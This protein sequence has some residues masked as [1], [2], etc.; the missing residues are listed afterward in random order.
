MY[1]QASVSKIVLPEQFDLGSV[2]SYNIPPPLDNPH[3]VRHKNITQ[4][5][6]NINNPKHIT[7][8]CFMPRRKI[9]AALASFDVT[10]KWLKQFY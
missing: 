4:I 5:E 8:A 1:V 7:L 10:S 2:C 6:N 3:P 9:N